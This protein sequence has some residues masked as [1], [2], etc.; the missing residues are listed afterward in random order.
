MTD[1]SNR[2]CHLQLDSTRHKLSGN[3]LLEN[4][5]EVSQHNSTSGLFWNPY[6]KTKQIFFWLRTCRTVGH[7]IDFIFIFQIDLKL[8]ILNGF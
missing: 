6:F 4:L 5:S 3:R 7:F 8:R 2:S 1:F